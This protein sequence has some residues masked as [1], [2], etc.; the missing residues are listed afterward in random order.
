MFCDSREVGQVYDVLAQCRQMG[1][2]GLSAD[3]LQQLF[4][5]NTSCEF[6]KQTSIKSCS[7]AALLRAEQGPC[8]PNEDFVSKFGEQ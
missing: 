5:C 2:M 4:R 1:P 7:A 3:Q 6:D 8:E